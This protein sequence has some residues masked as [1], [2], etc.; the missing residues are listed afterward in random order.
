MLLAVSNTIHS[1][2]IGAECV[3]AC[4]LCR[5]DTLLCSA[6]CEYLL[7]KYAGAVL[8]IGNVH[9]MFLSLVLVYALLFPKMRCM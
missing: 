2:A 9:H 4:A 1:S 6:L 5:I 3:T 7:A 8:C